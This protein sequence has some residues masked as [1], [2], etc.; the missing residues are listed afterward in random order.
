M[1]PKEHIR[2]AD[3]FSGAAISL[4]GLWVVSQAFRMPMKD[5]W[6]GVMNVWFV[7]PALMPLFVGSMIALLGALLCRRA[8]KDLP[9]GEL[10]ATVSW[11]C[12]RNLVRVLASD[13]T[14]R[15]YAIAV[16]FLVLVYLNLPRIDFFVSAYLF[17]FPLTTMFAFFDDRVLRRLLAFYLAGEACVFAYVVFDLPAIASATFRYVTDLVAL[18]FALAYTLYAWRLIRVA[19]DFR[20]KFRLGLTVALLAPLVV[21]T[22]FKYLL[23]VPLPKEG[24]ATSLLDAIWYLDF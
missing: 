20:R 15:F 11:L 18:G 5:S 1:L 8:L 7:S 24:L 3:V 21:G 2:K 12:S 9:Q 19:A 14:I 4:F 17:L 13:A 6:G 16:L 22:I 10:A 23:N